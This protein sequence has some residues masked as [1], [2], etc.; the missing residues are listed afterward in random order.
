[1][2]IFDGAFIV[3]D[4]LELLLKQC[5]RACSK[6]GQLTDKVLLFFLERCT[7]GFDLGKTSGFLVILKS[8]GVTIQL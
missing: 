8:K 3:F 4:L 2:A 5:L 7:T 1:M 6:T